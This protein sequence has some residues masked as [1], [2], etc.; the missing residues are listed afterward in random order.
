VGHVSLS[1]YNK[2]NW[3]EYT[4]YLYNMIQFNQTSL[5]NLS[6]PKSQDFLYGQIVF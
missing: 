2:H 6:T 3:L 1:I 5:Y 4:F